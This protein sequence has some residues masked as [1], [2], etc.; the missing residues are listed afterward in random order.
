MTK[1]DSGVCFS[2]FVGGLFVDVLWTGGSGP[3]PVLTRIVDSTGSGTGTQAGLT[4]TCNL[5]N[6]QSGLTR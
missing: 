2:F 1:N 5:D 3:S 4:V 6:Q